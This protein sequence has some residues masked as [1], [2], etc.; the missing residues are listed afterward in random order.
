MVRDEVLASLPPDPEVVEL[1]R[2]RAEGLCQGLAVRKVLR[3]VQ[4]AI[5]EEQLCTGQRAL[6]VIESRD[7]LGLRQ[8][9]NIPRLPSHTS[10]L[11]A[12]LS[13]SRLE[14]ACLLRAQLCLCPSDPNRAN[15]KKVEGNRIIALDFGGYGF[16]PPS[17]FTFVL[18]HADPSGFTYPI[19]RRVV[20]PPSTTEAVVMVFRRSSSP[21]FGKHGAQA[22]TPS[23]R[24]RSPFSPPHRHICELSIRPRDVTFS[25]STTQFLIN[26][27][28]FDSSR[29]R[30][31]S[32]ILSYMQRS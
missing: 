32:V 20:Y 12:F 24:P 3:P 13:R 29:D 9:L 6:T 11:L 22:V 26:G 16:L 28:I 21:G 7:V 19:A 4:V 25:P 30:K 10:L 5:S 31:G 17:F 14:R 8:Q 27:G 2:Q 23:T 18:D 1:E 15:F